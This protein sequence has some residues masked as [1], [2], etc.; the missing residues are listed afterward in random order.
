[1]F[2]KEIYLIKKINENEIG[3]KLHHF[4]IS[5]RIEDASL[6]YW[7]REIL[8]GYSP[9]IFSSILTPYKSQ[10]LHFELFVL[11]EL[12]LRNAK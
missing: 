3:A 10:I 2:G 4:F 5:L 6:N 9:V 11:Q 12:F 7:Q 1:M 8:F